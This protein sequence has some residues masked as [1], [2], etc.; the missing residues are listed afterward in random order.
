M[1]TEALY[2]NIKEY[3]ARTEI[4]I[5]QLE[6]ELHFGTGA[7]G[8]W[9]QSFPSVEKVVA[10][11]QF[12]DTSVDE[13]CGLKK[14]TEVASSEF[15]ESLI[16]K[17]LKGEVFWYQCASCDLVKN[18][19]CPPFRYSEKNELYRADYDAG[20]LFVK[21]EENDSILYISIED[22]VCI[23]QN[24]NIQ[25]IK[26]LWNIIKDKEHQRQ[27]KID[28]YKKSFFDVLN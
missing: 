27:E 25:K 13:L 18:N 2:V 20:S 17:T 23:R 28:E 15:M 21:Y 11:A 6:K 7:I 3:C 19:F 22:N 10:V 5:S 12:F 8:K 4:S 26:E 9:K 24:E 1:N 16:M 14:E